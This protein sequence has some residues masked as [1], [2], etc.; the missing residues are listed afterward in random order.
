MSLP[1]SVQELLDILGEM[2]DCGCKS[3]VAASLL[4]LAWVIDTKFGG[5][6]REKLSDE[7]CMGIRKGIYG[8]FAEDNA[9]TLHVAASVTV[10]S[11]PCTYE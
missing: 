3:E 5:L 10:E 8:A 1:A 6:D 11:D 7:I 2:R 4:L 9:D